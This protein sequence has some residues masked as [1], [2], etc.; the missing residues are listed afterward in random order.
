MTYWAEIWRIRD[1]SCLAAVPGASFYNLQSSTR[2][3][4][5]WFFTTSFYCK[6]RYTTTAMDDQHIPRANKSLPNH[7][8]PSSH[9]DTAARSRALNQKLDVALLPLMSLLY[10]FNGLDRG[11]VGN[12]ET[13]GMPPATSHLS[14]D[15]VDQHPHPAGFTTDIGAKPDDL[16]E[17]VSLFFVTFVVLQPVS[18]AVGRYIGAKHWIPILMVSCARS[19]IPNWRLTCLIV[20]LG[21]CYGRAGVHQRPWYVSC[22]RTSSPTSSS[23][24]LWPFLVC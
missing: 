3:T 9:E 20:W 22:F 19:A 21:H 23:D 24:W 5:A 11:N 2:F 18:A 7:G 13:Q 6:L 17:A 15:R 14:P 1:G 12:A 10:L 8:N 4:L 16:N